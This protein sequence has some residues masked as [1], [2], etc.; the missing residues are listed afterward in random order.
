MLL[1][2]INKKKIKIYR[3]D[4][5]SILILIK[6]FTPSIGTNNCLKRYLNVNN[7]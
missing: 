7:N 2:R 3:K 1:K 4:T 5:Y 6:L